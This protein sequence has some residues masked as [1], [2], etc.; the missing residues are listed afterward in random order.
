[1]SYEIDSDERINID[2]PVKPAAPSFAQE[3]SSLPDPFSS[4]MN[5][6]FFNGGDRRILLDEVIHLCQFGN[7]L[8]AAI[9]DDGVGKSAFLSQARFEL[10][11]T[12][13]CCLID[14]DDS[15]SPEDIFSQI[16]SQ[17]ELPVSPASSVGEM[18]A[19][20]RHAMAEG[21]MHRVVV[22][23]DNAHTL[24][25]AILS[26]L[27]SLLQGHQGQHLHILMAGEKAL[28]DRLD[29]F[30][31]VDV[32]V[33][34]VTLNPFTLEE[35]KEYLEFKLATAGYPDDHF[36]DDGQ[37]ESLW[38]ESRGY[39]SQIAR[40]AEKYIFHK[41]LEIEDDISP[42]RGLPLV[43]MALLVVLL[44]AL[45]LALIYMGGDEDSTAQESEVPI[46][47]EAIV[48][49]AQN[50]QLS[51]P[52]PEGQQASAD[53]V[54]E[55]NTIQLPISAESSGPSALASS[56]PISARQPEADEQAKTSSQGE[57]DVGVADANSIEAIKDPE[58]SSPA[59]NDR[60][61]ANVSAELEA[62]QNQPT[63]KELQASLKEELAK[64]AEA[65]SVAPAPQVSR[66]SSA[67]YSGDEK[68][69]LS[70]KDSDY[71]LQ[72]LAAGQRASVQK[73]IDAQPNAKELRLI[74]V[75]RATKPWYLVVVGNY[76]DNAT[77]RKAIQSLP[78]DQ[79]NSGPWPRRVSDLKREIEAFRNK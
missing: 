50:S 24:S 79:V 43:H 63:Q 49:Q 11:E 18:I 65:L 1:M 57:A 41:D 19:T 39:A 2:R 35:T 53:T 9:G 36:L 33:Y 20:L 48:N 59:A 61:Q 45:I 71:V 32:L 26:A 46:V 28:V 73:F 17:L 8:V 77:A 21:N 58:S 13:F 3:M 55:T 78:Q 62:V 76:S 4:S 56:Q 7:N 27:I 40:V 66:A 54:R 42:A 74:E 69:L 60:P 15:M 37:L 16:V 72:V 47:P 25:D 22:I 6:V 29:R 68:W 70:L 14:G 67:P 12:A 31:M 23:V 38:K 10:S 5:H 34:D 30:E 75:R 52:E 51:Q 64:E 44:A